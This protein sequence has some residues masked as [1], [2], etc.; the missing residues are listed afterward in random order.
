MTTVPLT[1]PRGD[2]E[3]SGKE[4]SD[5]ASG[6]V[7]EGDTG[8]GRRAEIRGIGDVAQRIVK[9]AY[10]GHPRLHRALVVV[11]WVLTGVC[12]VAIATRLS[13]L[14]LI[15]I[16]LFGVGA[17]AL[18]RIRATDVEDHRRLLSWTGLFL[19]AVLVGFW[20]LS[21]VGRWVS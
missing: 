5:R 10:L 2:N 8:T 20:L 14:P 6:P 7:P 9:A 19:L 3:I 1:A 11:L 13:A 4:A 15:P 17:Y 12:L 16:P 21:V 18:R